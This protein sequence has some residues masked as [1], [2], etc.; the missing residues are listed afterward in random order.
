MGNVV[1]L[2]V[3][4]LLCVRPGNCGSIDHLDIT[5]VLLSVSGPMNQRFFAQVMDNKTNMHVWH[6][7]S[8][9]LV[10]TS[11]NP[12]E[13]LSILEAPKLEKLVLHPNTQLQQLIVGH[14]PLNRLTKSLYNLR[15]LSV[16]K[17]VIC[18]FNGTFNLAE[19][20]P[21]RNL[22]TFSLEANQL[23]EVTLQPGESSTATEPKAA[24]R[25]LDLSSNLFEHFNL[26]VLQ[27][28]PLLKVLRLPRNKLVTLGGSVF[29]QALEL[30]DVQ[31]NVLIELD[32]SG[33]DCSSLLYVYASDNK[34]S[35]FPAFGEAITSIQ[36]LNLN[37]NQLASLNVIELTKQPNLTTLMLSTNA[38]KSFS[39]DDGRNGTAMELPSLTSLDLRNNRIESL[40]LRGWQLP[41][42][43]K[44]RVLN[45]PLVTIPDDLL[46]RFP[47]LTKV[48]CYCPNVDCTWIQ[49]NVAH[50]RDRKFEMSVAH[51]G[52]TQMD[53]GY[54]CVTVPYVGCVRCPFE[55]NESE[56]TNP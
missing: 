48:D 55:R 10:V 25:M 2:L 41:S 9:R 43:V 44:L 45:N 26:S 6:S 22:T 51:Q 24:L 32:L 36:V 29:L 21:F 7:D 37:D 39:V 20:L 35:T 38:L 3:L 49:R 28:F 33:C 13:T 53:K 23:T 18:R 4:A 46:E 30:L 15:A 27:A 54:R 56:M 16:L 31:L 19:L 50:I 34:L 52:P 17:F 5:T 12:L 11:D 1:K 47:Q 14:C 40:D 42:L 8:R